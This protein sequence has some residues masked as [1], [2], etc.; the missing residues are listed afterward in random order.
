MAVG[1][2]APEQVGHG[3]VVNIPAGVQQQI[4]NVGAEDLVFLCVCT[5]R[6]WAGSYED[7]EDPPPSRRAELLHE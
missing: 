6:F 7:L 5:P 1:G 2:L 4:T 3:D